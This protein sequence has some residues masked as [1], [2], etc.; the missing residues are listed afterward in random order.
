MDGAPHDEVYLGFDLDSTASN[1]QFGF[2]Y[3]VGL[4]DVRLESACLKAAGGFPDRCVDGR[5][6]LIARQAVIDK[7]EIQV[8]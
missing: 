4:C 1:K 2:A 3:V 7:D 6:G 5:Q 8:D